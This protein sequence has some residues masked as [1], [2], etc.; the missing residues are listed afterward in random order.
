METKIRFS[1][2]VARSTFMRMPVALHSPRSAAAEDYES[3]V[4][5]YLNMI[6]DEDNGKI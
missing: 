5:E 3:L 4:N 2:V 1:G 6:G